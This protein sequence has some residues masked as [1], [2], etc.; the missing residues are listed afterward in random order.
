MTAA[1]YSL[2][3]YGNMI[4]DDARTDAYARAIGEAVRPGAIVVDIGTG[5]GL[6]ALLACRAG[7]RRVY[8]IEHGEVI[9]VARR[10]AADNGYRDSIEFIHAQSTQVE[11]PARADVVVADLHGVLPL[12]R[13]NVTAMADARRRFLKPGGVL[14]PGRES[15]WLACVD[16]PDLHRTVTTPWLDNKYG[17]DMQAARDLTANQWRRAV[18]G[19]GQLLSEPQR[20]GEIDYATIEDPA[21]ATSVT[22]SAAREGIAH[23]FCVWFDSTLVPGV[24]FSNSPA[25]AGLVY[26][27]A[28]FPWP[29]AVTLREGDTIVIRL[30]ASLIAGEYLWTW[31]S[32]VHDPRD[33][34]AARAR[35]TQS[36]FLAEPMT[37]E[38]LRRQSATHVPSLN[39]DGRVDRLVLQLM[40]E[41]IPVGEIARRLVAEFPG[42]FENW[43][44]ALTRV[45]DLSARYSR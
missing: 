13:A 1:E 2:S 17:L 15:L 32:R 20:C 43:D 12:F 23:G 21:Y 19:A 34:A 39:E 41:R 30:Q 16:A 44:G 18:V 5:T 22:L 6:F 33:P 24:G 29:E 42:R 4:A 37:A 7:A 10:I 3:G 40:G 35:F 38:R 14:I 31:K 9:E 27:S 36:D 11:L 28:Y 25:G 26:G 8:A 45:G